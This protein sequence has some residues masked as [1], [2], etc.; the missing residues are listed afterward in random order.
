MN[1]MIRMARRI[2]FHISSQKRPRNYRML[3]LSGSSIL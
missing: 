3:L 2:S 1:T